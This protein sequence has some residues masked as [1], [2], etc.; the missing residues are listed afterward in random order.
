[1]E[2]EVWKLA[3]SWNQPMRASERELYD[4]NDDG[5]EDFLAL[6]EGSRGH[7]NFRTRWGG[8]KASDL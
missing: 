2:V 7:Q 4:V 3:D 6:F 5:G 1:M 8:K